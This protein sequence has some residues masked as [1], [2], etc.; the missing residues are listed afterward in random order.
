MILPGRGTRKGQKRDELSERVEV[1]RLARLE[2]CI[3]FLLIPLYDIDNDSASGSEEDL[4]PYS[5]ASHIFIYCGFNGFQRA[6]L[7]GDDAVA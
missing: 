3:L 5:D 6:V 1:V 4:P 7:F 2:Y